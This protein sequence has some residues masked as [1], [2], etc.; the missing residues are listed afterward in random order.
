VLDTTFVQHERFTE[1]A[2]LAE[3]LPGVVVQVTPLRHDGFYVELT[4]LRLGDVV[5]VHGACSPLVLIA[6]PGA[7][8][9]ALQFP[10]ERVETLLLNG[11]VLPPRGF[12]L[13]GPRA[14]LVRSNTQDNT[15]A[16]L[17]MP[18]EV[19]DLHLS[20][21]SGGPVVKPGECE[22]RSATPANWDRMARLV[23]LATDMA[24]QAPDVFSTEPPRLAL[25]AALLCAAR[26][27]V[28]TSP[29]A[30]EPRRRRSAESWRRIV[31]GAEAYL[32]AHLDRPIYTEELCGA[33]AVSPAT[34]AEAF[35][36]TLG[37][38][39][40]RYLKLRRLNLVRAALLRRDG[41]TPLVKCVALSHGFW[42]LG[43]FSHDYREHFGETPTE[44]LAATNRQV[45]VAVDGPATS[46][47]GEPGSRRQAAGRTR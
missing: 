20:G 22:M 15:Y 19:A 30:L 41:G 6:M 26:D 44:T 7:A 8:T 14:E 42:H 13:Y 18:P 34:L 37:T 33:L 2:Q 16:V 12:G 38:S 39:P 5:L 9:V 1:P 46:A 3:A 45:P 32:Q 36:G 31:V 4:T 27:L 25:R 11:R 43:Q 17:V 40:H 23:R 21:D 10:M 35:Q 28:Q 29:D 24:R 47:A